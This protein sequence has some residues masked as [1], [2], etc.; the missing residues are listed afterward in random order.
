MERQEKQSSIRTFGQI[1]AFALIAWIL[2]FGVLNKI[3]LDWKAFVFLA[4]LEV[5]LVIP[6]I[7]E[8]NFFD[9]FKIKKGIDDIDTKLQSI[10]I[11][12]DV[13]SNAKAQSI[14][15]NNNFPNVT[16]FST[17]KES[18]TGSNIVPANAPD[19]KL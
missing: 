12:L 16:E 2:I 13:S 10:E 17:S 18:D 5:I 7:S 3:S 1:V 14:T 19:Q 9:L 6:W 15:Y 11:K 4:A 8:I